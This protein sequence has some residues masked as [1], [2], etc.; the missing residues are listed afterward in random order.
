[1]AV[2]GQVLA[3]GRMLVDNTLLAGEA[4]CQLS[5]GVRFGLG[6]ESVEESITL[7]SGQA[8][9]KALEA[10]FRGGT[11]RD[12]FEALAKFYQP[13]WEEWVRGTDVALAM[14]MSVDDL[15]KD[16]R[17]YENVHLVVANWLSNNPPE[18]WPFQVDPA[19]VEAG[20]E[21]LLDPVENIWYTGTP[22][23]GAVTLNGSRYA[24]DHKSTGRMT[25]EW[26][27]GF[28]TSGQVSG[29]LWGLQQVTGVTYIGMLVN[30]I[31][32]SKVPGS[33]RK[34]TEHGVPYAECGALHL[35]H[36]LWPVQRTPEQLEQ[37]KATAVWL[38]RRYKAR[39][40]GQVPISEIPTEGELTGACAYCACQDWCAG[41]RQ[42]SELTVR[43]QQKWWDPAQ[44]FTEGG[45]DA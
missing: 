37:W 29:Y 20:F 33:S 22:D 25:R 31:E 30:G 40:V 35:K 1:M 26:R 43:F 10:V 6:L 44:R 9:H 24:M 11:T 19:S 18:Q 15:K 12:A 16:R 27:N 8:I 14:G 45:E 39:V 21:V 38:A 2:H 3:D 5:A 4:R 41:G 17:S 13:K 23:V 42:A 34:C 32:L 28:R 36:D 7:V